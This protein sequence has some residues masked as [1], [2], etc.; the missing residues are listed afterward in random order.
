MR[1]S[2]QICIHSDKFSFSVFENSI[3]NAMFFAKFSSFFDE[4]LTFEKGF[5]GNCDRH[6]SKGILLHFFDGKQSLGMRLL[7]G[8]FSDFEFEEKVV[9]FGTE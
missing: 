1:Y 5:V 7:V 4:G 3:S 6:A 2:K 8:G 9:D